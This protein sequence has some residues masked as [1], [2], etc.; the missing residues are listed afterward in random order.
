MQTFYLL[1]CQILKE[2]VDFFII[3][4]SWIVLI[5]NGINPR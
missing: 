4:K 5:M 1:A 3:F 2:I